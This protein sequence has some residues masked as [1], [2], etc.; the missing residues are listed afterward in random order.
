[1]K[2]SE[3]AARAALAQFFSPADLAADLSAAPPAE[4]WEKRLQGDRTG[5]LTA[6]RP[7]AHLSTAEMT[8]KYLIPSDPEWPQTL[9]AL[10]PAC[11]LGIWV[12]GSKH[13]PHLLRSPVAVLG[14][15]AASP[16]GLERAE[17]FAAALA[18]A[19]HTVTATLA[20]GV[21]STAHRAAH[22]EAPS[23][24]VLPRGLDRCFPEG[25][26]PLMRSITAHDGA[27][28]SLIPP[29]TV[30]T[31]RSL[32]AAITLC[33]ALSRAVVLV[34]ALD[35]STVME[36]IRSTDALGR[37][38]FSPPAE[39]GDL[40]GTGNAHLISTGRATVTVTPADLLSQL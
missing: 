10:G 20:Y 22:L 27:V 17:A 7:H 31:G 16:R 25:S 1:M 12:S 28:V 24:A 8:C 29:G 6:H 2:V 3:R 18:R 23:L 14:N 38:V 5:R 37:R 15:R 13:L 19:G 40:V 39:A 26:S 4:V 21:D 35:H 11:P 32:R 9:T 36:S 30:A 34:E 33:T